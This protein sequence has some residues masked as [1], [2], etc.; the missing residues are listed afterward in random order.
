MSKAPGSQRDAYARIRGLGVVCVTYRVGGLKVANATA[1]AFAENRPSSVI[2]GARGI[3]ERERNPLLHHKVREF[4]TQ[5][6]VFEQLTVA[7]TVL[8]DPPNGI[9]GDRPRLACRLCV[10]AAGLY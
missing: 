2:G 5:R 10:Q 6:K 1:G 3:K 8:S 7:S 4:D 9:P